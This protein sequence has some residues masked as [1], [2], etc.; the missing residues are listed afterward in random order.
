MTHLMDV[1]DLKWEKI[2]DDQYYMSRAQYDA[3]N[4]QL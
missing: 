4:E 2:E 3:C 1:P